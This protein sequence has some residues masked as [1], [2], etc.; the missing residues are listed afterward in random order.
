MEPHG[1]VVGTGAVIQSGRSWAR[2]PTMSS[3]SLNLPNHSS[4]TIFLELTQILTEM[5][6]MNFPGGKSAAEA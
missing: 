3:D 1:I 4:C 6:A 5:R 2:F